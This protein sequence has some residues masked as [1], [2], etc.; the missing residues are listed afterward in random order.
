MLLQTLYQIFEQVVFKGARGEEFG[1]QGLGKLQERFPII[2]KKTSKCPLLIP[3][4]LY[5]QVPLD[6]YSPPLLKLK[7][8]IVLYIFILQKSFLSLYILERPR[9]GLCVNQRQV[10]LEQSSIYETWKMF[11]TN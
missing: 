5:S 11:P 10:S 3:T 8:L 9:L 2:E 4:S 1:G 7:S 6:P